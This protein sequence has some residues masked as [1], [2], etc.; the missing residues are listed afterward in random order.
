MDIS[1]QFKEFSQ[2]H[3]T[4]CQLKLSVSLFPQFQSDLMP[5]CDTFFLLS[6]CLPPKPMMYNGYM[7]VCVCVYHVYDEKK[8]TIKNAQIDIIWMEQWQ[9]APSARRTLSFLL[10]STHR[11]WGFPGV[12]PCL[13][14][15]LVQAGPLPCALMT[16]QGFCSTSLGP[17]P[18]L[19][20]L[21]GGK[22]GSSK[23]PLA[24]SSFLM[25]ERYHHLSPAGT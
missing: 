7:S 13:P 20:L 9:R 12:L 18:T 25:K 1:S 2:D 6:H 17:T 3:I 16:E 23:G 11:A 21:P 5:F 22:P 8:M 19:S 10:R 4:K 15:P 24:C 14:P